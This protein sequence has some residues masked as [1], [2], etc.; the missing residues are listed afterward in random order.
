MVLNY[1][2]I[3]KVLGAI[4]VILGISMVP[5]LLI[6]VFNQ[7]TQAIIG[8]LTAII[9][10]VIIGLFVQKIK[11][12]SHNIKIRDGYAIVSLCWVV[13]S[14]FGAL[15]FFFSGAIPNYADAFFETVSGFTTTG[16]SILTDVEIMPRGLLFWR[17]FTHWLG[18]MGILVFAIALLPALGIGGQQ[19]AQAE[20]PGPTMDK[21]TPKMSDTAKILYII[22]ISMTLIEVLLLLLGGMSLFDAFI[23]TFGTMGTGGFSNYN[24]SVGYFNSVYI[25][26]VIG[27]FMILAGANFNLYYDVLK[28][29]WRDFIGDHEFRLYLFILAAAMIAIAANLWLTGTYDSIFQAFRYSFFQT[30]SIQTT[31]GFASTN[32]D[33]WPTFSKMVLFTLM[34]IGGCSAS[35]AGSVKVIRVL[36]VFKLINREIFRKMHPRAVVPVK[37]DGRPVPSGTVSSIASFMFLYFLLFL[38]GTLLISI[39]DFG[40]VTS[41]SAVAATLGNVGPGFE[42]V[43]PVMNY[44]LFSDASTLLLSLLMLAG[45]LE[46]FTIILLF[47]PGYWDPD[48]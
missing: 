37:V 5:S 20:T 39:E 35:T 34:F 6:S 12:T 33:L 13:G 47:S 26:I 40:L 44:S 31:T 7:E 27:I 14:M 2:M 29:R 15:P 19:I 1:R 36:V 45:R 8:F 24:A 4:M 30:A 46:L 41:A 11:L 48:R 16:A 18:G 32:F 43:G 25:D 28:G 22:Y 38:A 42:L 3:A 10:M 9:P 17:S 23:Q 21:I